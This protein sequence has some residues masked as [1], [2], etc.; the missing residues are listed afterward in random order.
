MYMQIEEKYMKYYY[1]LW[2]GKLDTLLQFI[3]NVHQLWLK[4]YEKVFNVEKQ[5]VYDNLQIIYDIAQ[6]CIIIFNDKLPFKCYIEPNESFVY[7]ESDQKFKVIDLNNT[8]CYNI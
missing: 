3:K 2:N 5:L 7:L 4:Y 1:V 8:T 6:N